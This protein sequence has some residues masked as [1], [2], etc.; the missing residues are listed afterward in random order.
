MFDK[1][2]DLHEHF[3]SQEGFHPEDVLVEYLLIKRAKDNSFSGEGN[4]TVE[5]SS[6]V[7]A[8]LASLP[9]GT[10]NFGEN[11][12]DA[13]VRNTF[14]QTGYDLTDHENFCLVAQSR[15][16]YAMRYLPNKRVITAKPFVF[17][18]LYPG[19]LQPSPNFVPDEQKVTL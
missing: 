2:D 13:V 7:F 4:D 9:G 10:N 19:I 17:L 15:S 16:N 8:G 18:Q 1:G 12:L 5:K 6:N 14:E 11:N 3:L